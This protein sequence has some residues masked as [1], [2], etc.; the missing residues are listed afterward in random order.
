MAKRGT[1]GNFF[2]GPASVAVGEGDILRVVRQAGGVP[3]FNS[4]AGYLIKNPNNGLYNAINMLT[5]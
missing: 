3:S 1:D 5:S 4:R 2:R